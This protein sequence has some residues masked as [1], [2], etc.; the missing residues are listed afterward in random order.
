[1]LPEVTLKKNLF[2]MSK[3]TFPSPIWSTKIC[4][5]TKKVMANQSLYLYYVQGHMSLLDFKRF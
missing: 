2:L 5:N 4:K 1:M 3:G